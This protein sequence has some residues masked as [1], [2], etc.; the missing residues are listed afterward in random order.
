MLRDDTMIVVNFVGIALSII[1]LM[2]YYQYSP[3]KTGVWAK[4]GLAGAFSA[5]CVG[6][7][8]YEDPSIVEYRYGLIITAFM[9]WL[10]ASP[11]FGLVSFY[12]RYLLV[13][14]CRSPVTTMA[15]C[16]VGH[17]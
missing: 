16:G 13:L 11:L 15:M 2:I 6:Y 9:F 10:I 14:L 12:T 17:P 8:E 7:T 5:A 3:S 1:Y 4:M